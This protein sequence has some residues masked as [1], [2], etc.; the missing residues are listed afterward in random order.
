MQ[1]SINDKYLKV[2]RILKTKTKT[3]EKHQN[4]KKQKMGIPQ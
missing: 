1:N 2:L 3:L 4:S